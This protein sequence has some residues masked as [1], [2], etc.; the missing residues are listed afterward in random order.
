M[1]TPAGL[2][3]ALAATP[4]AAETLVVDDQVQLR[5]PAVEL[6]TARLPA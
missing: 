5:P 3:L 1:K 6:P 2:L 4:L